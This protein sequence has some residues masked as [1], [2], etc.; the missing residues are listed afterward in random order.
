MTAAPI[1]LNTFDVG[2]VVGASLGVIR[3][4][5]L[6]IAVIILLR[7]ALG[8][9]YS[10]QNLPSYKRG[11]HDPGAF[12]IYCAVSA[13]FMF[14]AWLKSAAITSV[15]LEQAVDR[16][17]LIE[18]VGDALRSFPTLLPFRLVDELST[19]V[20][21][22]LL[23][24]A[25]DSAFHFGLDYWLRE[26]AYWV[27]GLTVTAFWGLT[28]PIVLAERQG[29]LSSL[30]RSAALLSLAR[31]RFLAMLLLITVVAVLADFAHSALTFFIIRNLP[32]TSWSVFSRYDHL[33]GDLLSSILDAIW[34][35]IVAMSYR[36][37]CR[38][39]DGAEHDQIGR[40]FT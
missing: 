12:A 23:W 27:F 24:A 37:F 2:R 30:R 25:T 38:L 1:R 18:A 19:G 33:A 8:V 13:A 6:P 15:A 26:L 28:V 7:W 39:H 5:W 21:L 3:R 16:S 10:F 20:D 22:W 31:W 35:V 11:S 34:F 9:T 4:R 14:V 40:V 36:E 32:E 17:P 29:I